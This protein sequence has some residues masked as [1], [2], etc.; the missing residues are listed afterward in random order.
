M[1]KLFQRKFE[2]R[3]PEVKTNMAENGVSCPACGWRKSV[4]ID[5]ATNR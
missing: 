3:T 1:K 4:I 2:R 5:A